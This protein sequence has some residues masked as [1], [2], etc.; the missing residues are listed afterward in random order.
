[1]PRHKFNPDWN[2]HYNFDDKANQAEIVKVDSYDIAHDANI[3]APGDKIASPWGDN[4]VLSVSQQGGQDVCIKEITVKPGFML[5]L[6][7]HRGREELWEVKTGILTVIADGKR[8]EV[9]AGD[10]I[11]LP[12]GAVHCM[13]NVHDAPVTVIE[14]QIGINREADNIRLIDFNNR[15]IYPLTSEVEFASA[16]LYAQM[17][18]DIARRFGTGNHP[19]KTLLEA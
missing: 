5:S 4:Q 7:R 18:E 15:P 8:I 12:K 19:H 2:P 6:Q 11:R 1:M 17:Q 3:Y 14:T 16:K 9:G 13:N 10:S